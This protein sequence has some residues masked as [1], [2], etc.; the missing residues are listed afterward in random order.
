MRIISIILI[1]V[2]ISW[3]PLKGQQLGQYTQYFSNELIINPAFAGA[4]ES[5]SLTLL[6]RGQWSG[7][8]GAPSTQT[9][10]AHSLFKNKH[11]G[12]G[13]SIINDKIGIHRNL[14]F[15]TSY[16]YI[17][18]V[19][20]DAYFSL[21]LQLGMNQTQSDFAAI[22]NQILNQNDPSI[23]GFKESVSALTIGTGLFY[24]DSR[25][26]I[27]LSAPNLFSSRTR[28]ND[29]ISS[30][31][32]KT[33]YFLYSRYRVPVNRNLKLQPGLLIKYLDGLPLS[34]DFHLAA[35]INEVLLTGLSYRSFESIGLI[36][37]AKITPQLKAGYGF[38]YPLGSVGELSRSSH[39]IMLNYLF[40]F[41]RYKVKRPR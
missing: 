11:I 5:L 2:S 32:N 27:G 17:L 29:S 39:E 35:I 38:D 16:A 1:L 8:E 4:Q 13:A 36:L 40:K 19:K 14:T 9:L 31:L 30:D 24:R 21:G 7:L 33:H 23:S 26:Q 15:N 37:Q 3:W 22:S 28:L 18:Q 41:S 6:H 34:M 12:L 25:F 10:S 20:K